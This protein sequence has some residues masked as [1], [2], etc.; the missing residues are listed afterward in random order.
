MKN[1]EYIEEED[2]KNIRD[3]IGYYFEGSDGYLKRNI[4]IEFSHSLNVERCIKLTEKIKNEFGIERNRLIQYLETSYKFN[5]SEIN[6]LYEKI[7]SLKE[8]NKKL[9]NITEG[10][11]KTSTFWE[12]FKYLLNYK[13]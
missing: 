12:S 7:K 6:R 1:I 3:K 2:L 13:V 5:E 8:A 4:D 11:I 10:V 9:E